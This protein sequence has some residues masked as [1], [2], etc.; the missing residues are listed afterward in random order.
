MSEDNYG[1]DNIQELE[2]LDAVRKRPG[3][4]IGSTN[5]RGLHHMVQEV[6]DNGVD[7]AMAGYADQ[8]DVIVHEDGSVSVEDNG[9]GIPVD[10]KD[11]EPAINVIMTSIH[12]G[13]KFDSEAYAVSGGLH[14]VG[15]SVVNALSNK[16]VAEI[17]RDGYKWRQVFNDGV[18]QGIERVREAEGEE[19]GSTVRFWPSE[20]T[21][22]TTNFEYKK[23]RSRL[24]NLAYL[25]PEVEF[26]IED[27][28]E[29]ETKSDTYLFERGIG[30]F[31][32]HLN[33]GRE[34]LHKDVVRIRGEERTEQQ[35]QVAVDIALQYTDSTDTSMYSFANNIET[36]DGGEHE[37]GFKTSLT[38]V[39]NSY[40]E[41]RGMLEAV[42]GDRLGGGIVREG[43]TVVISV[44]HSEPQFEGQT[45]A[46]LGNRDARGV[47]S[48]LV[49]DELSR[50]LEEHPDMAEA[51]VNK[52]VKAFKAKK[53]AQKAEELERKSATTSTRLPGKLSDCQKGTPPE[54]GELFVVE[55]DSAGGC[56]TGDTEIALASGESM[57]FEELVDEYEDENAHYC[58][59]VDDDG[60]IQIGQIKNPRVTK[61]NAELVEVTLANG[62]KIKCTPDHKF[63]LRDGEYRQAGNL[64]KGDS[65]MP[66]YTKT[67]DTDEDGITID[68]YEMVNQPIMN[69]F[70]EFTHLLADRFN[71]RNDRY[72]D[73]D[74][75][76]KHHIDFD[77]RNNRPDNIRRMD[78]EEHLELHRE[79]VEE[80]LL[81][82]EVLEK[83]RE[84]KQSEEYRE[85]MSERMQKEE[86]AEMLRQQAIE[87]W[88]D[89]E[90][91]QYMMEAWREFYENNPEAVEE[92]RRQAEEQWDDEELREW[93]S[94]KTEEQW[95]E[96]FRED[97]MESY[98]QTYYE[99]TMPFMKK[100]ME[101]DD[102]IEN[103]DE[104][105]AE[106]ND[107][108]V[109]TVKT[110]IEKFFDDKEELVEAV[111]SYNH[112]VESVVELDE[113]E[114]VYDIEVPETH[115]FALESGVFVHNSAKQARNPENQAILPLRGKILNVEK[116]RLSKI[117][118]HD[119]IQNLITA[120]GTGIDDDFNIDDLRYHTIIMFSVAGDEHAFVRSPEGQI[121]MVE[122]GSFIDEAVETDGDAHEDYEVMCF[123]RDSHRTKFEPISQVIRHKISEPL[124]KVTTKYG[125]NVKATASH[126]IF[127]YEDGEV[128][129]KQT[130]EI[131]EDD[132][133]VA[134]RRN[135][136]EG[137]EFGS[138]PER[139][140]LLEELVKMD[141]LEH[142]IYA[143]GEGIRHFYQ[144]QVL[145]DHTDNPELSEKRVKPTKEQLSRLKSTRNEMDIAQYEVCDEIDVEQPIT[146]SQWERGNTR[147][148]VSNFRAW[149][150]KL[151][152]DATEMLEGANVEDSLIEQRW[153]NQY[154]ESTQKNRVRE[155]I[156]VQELNRE[157]L[158]LI[159]N[160]DEVMLTPAKYADNG[161][162]RYIDIDESLL[163]L[164]GFW[165]AEGSCSDG[166][167]IR[168][169]M[170][171]NNQHL[172]EHYK[173]RFDEV[174]GIS[175]KHSELEE[176][177]DEVKLVNRV[178]AVIWQRVLGLDA[179][180]ASDKKVSN[181]VFN[182]GENLQD[183]WIRGYTR[184]DGSLHSNGV[185]SWSTTSR[186]LS[187]GLV[188]LL[189]ARGIVPSTTKH[190]VA[191]ET[192]DVSSYSS[193]SNRDEIEQQYDKYEIS[194]SANED[195]RRLDDVWDEIEG[196][197]S[198]SNNLGRETEREFVQISD[199]LMAVPVRSNE[200]VKTEEDKYV[201]DFA[202]EN[203]HTFI[204]GNGGIAAH[205]T[206]A[207]VDG[208]H[209]KTLLLT[210]IFRHMP[211]L[212][213][214]G[215][216]Y[217]VK[218]P[219]YRIRNNGKTYDAM[220]D[221]EREEIVENKCN[222]NADNVQ[223]FKGLG[224]MNP[225]QLWDTTMDPE[226]RRLE[227][228]TI[229]DAAKAD[230][231]FSV[232][233]GSQVEPRREFIRENSDEA[234][235]IDI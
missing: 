70:W 66:L 53:A 46:K 200:R 52:A 99:N 134:P 220:T 12:A 215:H 115:N 225:Q 11:G 13:G 152:F 170:G 56:F 80:T 155:Y 89:D 189:S 119:Q 129:T 139:F 186:D 37:T 179:D 6:V 18:P 162:N 181:L 234:D 141:D 136:L 149:C 9:R 73:E 226:E 58:Y 123:D 75:S 4:Y 154:S 169:A 168:L 85:K 32:E 29:E 33:E 138:T 26:T 98:N 40:A 135:P 128:T 121:E 96:E 38:R 229:D 43:L 174:F 1:A 114:D 197:K 153:N 14:G 148:T 228:I 127:V 91:K 84:I 92:R 55:G 90:Y 23:L 110:T 116:N 65:L 50:H 60:R 166:N 176:H 34:S 182:V 41:E 157:D 7:E 118:E 194:L 125:R 124:H 76:H 81:S 109:L 219:L 177:T 36:P 72:D 206:D 93:R 172:I 94:K 42:D 103:H 196:H 180:H 151:G 233:M 83:I 82:E 173:N 167:G 213:E 48:G 150:E 198:I 22:E 231:I 112:S 78:S 27:R 178:A 203:N 205:N 171:R 214:N 28:R 132:Y 79:H 131:T 62:E 211:E 143:R 95:T 2:G 190:D 102:S 140:D 10:D 204:A 216:V 160:D 105:R 64:Q 199:D 147:P 209:I 45:K 15:V 30:E 17:T 35:E 159:P 71:I 185:I 44:K 183:S 202:V 39:I 51:I 156:D 67:S 217:A 120:L 88:E 104:K 145:D 113:T 146:I 68:G 61:H 175:A 207:D 210:F 126:S 187:S 111:E 130:D 142:T 222:G 191:G 100:V 19:T 107:P 223:R 3:M 77:K 184:G 230:R 86:T 101:E 59:T 106:K 97:R 117:L 235:W 192:I 224:E 163:D 218:S 24:E 69:D 165:T 87:Q 25:N 188:Y 208:A 227:R 20:D 137:T 122:I 74:G 63:M 201:Y 108:N 8:I 47:V 21:F 232:L 31:V 193:V 133:V 49:T 164:M 212:L 195:I 221:A 54:E 5:S 16:L 158:E 144:K 57:S 161:I